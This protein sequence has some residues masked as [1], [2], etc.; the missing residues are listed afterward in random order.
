MH[1]GIDARMYGPNNRGIGRYIQRLIEGLARIDDN[2][3][4][5]LF[6]TKKSMENFVV[7]NGKFKIVCAD[8][9]W[10]GLKEQIL[11]PWFIKKNK[12]DI[13]HWP[14]INVPYF[15]PVPYVVTVHDLIVWHFPD[16]RATTLPTWKYNI[17][18]WAYKK[19]MTRAIARAK[20]VITI[21][22]F[23][24]RDIIKQFKTKDNKITVAY[25]GTDKM[26]LG[27]EKISNSES[28]NE[29]LSSRFNIK[30]S[31]L[32]YVGSAYPHKNLEKLIRAF[33]ITK[34]QYNR[35]W[36]LV[37]VGRNDW[38]YEKL[39]QFINSTISDE[40]IK[41]DILL[42]G[43]VSDKDL[44]G[45]YRG[46]RIFVFPSLYEGFGLPP[47]EAAS[48]GVVVA[49]AKTAS[50]PEIMADA[51]YYFDP[52]SVENMAQALDIL[53]GARQTQTELIARGFE[54]VKQFSW[55]KMAKEISDVYSSLG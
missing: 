3:R 1:I 7:P 12:V 36:H 8:I 27:M 31:F 47:L 17:K 49:A 33:V 22:Q 40:E 23:T 15:C 11:M 50:L 53:A 6:M 35:N 45:L 24:K 26:L 32:L 5:T 55:N 9:A 4:Y 16:S 41:K 38:F 34:N 14:H 25:P 2:N 28:F 52:D 19:I 29:Y 13:M 37:L 21:S 44:D 51:A 48:R 39:K 20:K 18:L 43:Q 42:L 30:K 54:R 10:Y 46:A